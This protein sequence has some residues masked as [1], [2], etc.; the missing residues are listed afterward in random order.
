LAEHKSEGFAVCPPKPCGSVNPD[1]GWIEQIGFKFAHQS[2]LQNMV[3]VDG[4]QVHQGCQ[5]RIGVI[6][7]ILAK[8]V[9]HQTAVAV[10]G[11]ASSGGVDAPKT[12]DDGKA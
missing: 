9:N 3:L 7:K 4:S 11:G 10:M 12:D 2:V 6:S 8:L 5:R 1:C